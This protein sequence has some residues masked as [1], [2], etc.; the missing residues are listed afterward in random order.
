MS[1][2]ADFDKWWGNNSFELGEWRSVA[3]AA[4]F[5]GRSDGL[6]FARR[7]LEEARML[8]QNIAPGLPQKLASK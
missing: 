7:E 3:A 2:Q 1:A 5:A 6:E 8:H 4:Y